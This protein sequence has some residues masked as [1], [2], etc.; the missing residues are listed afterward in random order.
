MTSSP[1]H[2]PTL[3]RARSTSCWRTTAKATGTRAT[4]EIHSSH[5]P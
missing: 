3:S 5:P 4:K 2:L 1:I